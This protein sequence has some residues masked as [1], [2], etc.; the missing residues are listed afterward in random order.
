[1]IHSSGEPYEEPRRREYPSMVMSGPQL[2]SHVQVQC[3]EVFT[4]QNCFCSFGCFQPPSRPLSV[5]N[6]WRIWRLLRD[7]SANPRGFT[8]ATCRLTQR[9]P[10]SCAFRVLP[11]RRQPLLRAGEGDQSGEPGAAAAGAPYTHPSL[12]VNKTTL[13]PTALPAPGVHLHNWTCGF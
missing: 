11:D 13:C 12:D 6:P 8:D 1:M 4:L 2:C 10:A 5:T 3:L 7:A 9:A